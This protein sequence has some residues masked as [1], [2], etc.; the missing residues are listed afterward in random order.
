MEELAENICICIIF[1]YYV[2][3]HHRKTNSFLKDRE[4]M[5]PSI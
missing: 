2:A 3:G 4:R 5:F 1:V